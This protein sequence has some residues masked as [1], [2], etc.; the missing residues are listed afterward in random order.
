MKLK[1]W[2]VMCWID[3]HINHP[4]WELIDPNNNG[5][6]LD[7]IMY[8]FCQWAWVNRFKEEDKQ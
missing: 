3:D 5:T 1:F 2:E 6:F 4:F 7:P 8:R